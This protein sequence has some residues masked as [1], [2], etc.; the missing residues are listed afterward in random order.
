[1]LK[2]VSLLTQFGTPHEWTDEFL[3]NIGTLGKYGW[4]WKIFTPNKFE[5][6]PQNVEV[7]DMDIDG[8][9]K[10]VNQKLGFDP[11]VKINDKGF[12]SK[13][14]SD[15]YVAN[16]VIFEDY[17]KSFDY[18]T[19]TN[20]DVV[21]GRLDHFLPDIMLKTMDIFTDDIGIVNGVFSV[22]KNTP[23]VN[24]LFREIPDIEE[25]MKSEDIIG[26]DE[27]YLITPIKRAA[28][29][30]KIVYNHPEY[31][32]FHSYDRLIQHS[33]GPQLEIRKDGSLWERFKDMNPP[34]GYINFPK[35]Y[36]AREIMY[37]HFSYTKKWPYPEFVFDKGE[38]E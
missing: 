20:W 6:I 10:L 7:V 3:K 28:A 32:P 22:F 11:E 23:V 4:Y 21:Y 18:W 37:F 14:M 16:G 15:F 5:N 17:I 24:N 27:Y 8:F 31:Y 12:P 35:G 1:M 34:K 29:L 9:N 19:I 26:T 33:E 36:I 30:N 13:P 25:M 38:L 2:K